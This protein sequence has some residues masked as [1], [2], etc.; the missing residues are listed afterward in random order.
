MSK[1]VAL[2]YISE[3][4]YYIILLDIWSESSIEVIFDIF[5][6]YIVSY[7]RKRWEIG[8]FIYISIFSFTYLSIYL[9][10]LM[11]IFV[12]LLVKVDACGELR[13]NRSLLQG[14]Y[15]FPRIFGKI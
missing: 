7:F 13:S 3:V 14:V 9:I 6:M 8:I 10:Y 12:G 4:F 11:I 2:K 5:M 15:L 1:H